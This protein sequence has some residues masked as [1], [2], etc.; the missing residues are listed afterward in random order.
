MKSDIFP[1]AQSAIGSIDWCTRPLA[2]FRDDGQTAEA[3]KA[4]VN[5]HKG[6]T[7]RNRSLPYT[8]RKKLKTCLCKFTKKTT[9]NSRNAS[10]LARS[11]HHVHCFCQRRTHSTSNQILHMYD[12]YRVFIICILFFGRCSAAISYHSTVIYHCTLLPYN[13]K[14]P[15]TKQAQEM[16]HRTS[17]DM[18]VNVVILRHSAAQ[19]HFM[20]KH[21]HKTNT[22]QL[23]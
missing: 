15:L 6:H 9:A 18:Y 16:Q 17:S 13:K 23:Q 8:A 5:T 14:L 19:K 4:E 7:H 11:G 12:T 20:H 22:W 3:C 1:Q 2:R 21:R 10:F